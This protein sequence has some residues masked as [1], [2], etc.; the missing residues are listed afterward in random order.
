M[1]E[2]IDKESVE[3]G[4]C[5]KR[6]E[7]A[8][9]DST[10]ELDETER[11]IIV[12]SARHSALR[13]FGMNLYSTLVVCV[14]YLFSW[15]TLASCSLGVALTVYFYYVFDDDDSWDGGGLSW[16]L[17]SFAIIT[18]MSSSIGMAFNRREVALKAISVLRADAYNIYSAHANWDWRI[19]NHTT[20]DPTGRDSRTKFSSLHHSDQVLTTLLDM[21]QEL[22]QLLT[23]PCITRAR[24]RVT[25][26]GKH[27]YSR[28]TVLNKQA[29]RSVIALHINTL[30]L[31]CEHIK[32]EGLPANEASRIRQWEHSM[33][34]QINILRHIKTYR[35]PQALRSF[36]RLFVIILPGFYAPYF[37]QVA[38][39]L[40]S[41]PFGLIF[42]LLTSI[43]LTAL[44]ESIR[45]LEDPF[46][47]TTTLDGID[48]NDELDALLRA[49]LI[50]ARAFFFPYADKLDLKPLIKE[51][52][53]KF[54]DTSKH[55]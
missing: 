29:M 9:E 21:G 17:L 31:K 34:Q 45:V 46:V 16:T 30:T 32:Q 51:E 43:A 35:T 54:L 28:L 47:A 25:K 22:A 39:D 15:E 23:L 37:A 3:E 36:A 42:T 10:T 2:Q 14:F 55:T 52:S 26:Q 4:E 18:P 44:F 27:E 6:I 50:D 53:K 48:I 40:R 11:E 33:L 41:L 8:G 13:L 20:A 5:S 12:Q 7:E 38:R 19:P 24:H 49:E 1:N